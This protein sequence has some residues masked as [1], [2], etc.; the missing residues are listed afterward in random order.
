MAFM[1]FVLLL[2]GG[3]VA[4]SYSPLIDH[5]MKPLRPESPPEP[6]SDEARGTPAPDNTIK[7]SRPDFPAPD[8][9]TTTSPLRSPD[10]EGAP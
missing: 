5:L 7:E 1:L 4:L 8:N 6:I 2:I 3:V 10:V 9:P